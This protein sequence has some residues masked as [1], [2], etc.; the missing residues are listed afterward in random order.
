MEKPEPSLAEA[1]RLKNANDMLRKRIQML[2]AEL[3]RLKMK[4]IN[5][6]GEA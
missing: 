2:E 6:W 3:A 5:T 1:A 4:V